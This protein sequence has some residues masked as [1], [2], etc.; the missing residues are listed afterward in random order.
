MKIGPISSF[1]LFC[2]GTSKDIISKCPSFEIIK[3]STIGVTIILTTILALLSGFYAL[4]IIFENIYV[5]VFG[6][7][8]WGVIIFNLDRYI[9]IS[10]RPTES[11]TSN[12]I[13]SLPRF[14]IA[15]VVAVV[16][17]K[18][19]EIKLFENEINNFLELETLQRIEIV[20]E[21]INQKLLELENR[22]DKL[23]IA[24]QKKVDIVNGYKE[25]YLCEGSGTC[26]T[27]IRGRGIEF[28]SRKER[29]VNEAAKLELEKI[30]KDSIINELIS[31]EKNMLIAYSEEKNVIKSNKYGFFD[32]VK[33]LNSVNIVAS[34]FILFIFILVET[35]PML[36]KI[37]SRKGPYDLLIM[38][39]EFQFESDY[40]NESDSLK[41][42]R[43]KNEKINQINADV[44]LDT[45]KKLI[46]NINAQDAFNRYENLK[47]E[48]VG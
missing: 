30:K 20:D 33:A 14:F 7:I 38:Q 48:E 19:I 6:S 18:P 23:E 26:G 25:D 47:D 34:Y 17:S 24:F 41:I 2:S 42:L 40:L 43:L 9:V 44:D 39:A 13:I 36:T 16:I 5:S 31:F 12:L 10:L 32:R 8:F 37:L 22:K 11:L 46:E 27:M 28:Q 15:L 4:S 35:S 21:K 45:R 29:W 1:F 3:Y